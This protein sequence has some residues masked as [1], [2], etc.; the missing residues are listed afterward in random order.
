[1]QPPPPV[2]ETYVTPPN[3]LDR[4]AAFG[5]MATFAIVLAYEP[6]MWVDQHTFPL[7]GYVVYPVE[8]TV[9]KILFPEA[10]TPFRGNIGA[11]LIGMLY[12]AI[13]ALGVGVLGVILGVFGW[14]FRGATFLHH[15]FSVV[16]AFV[17]AMHRRIATLRNRA[18]R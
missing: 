7:L 10:M 17:R 11:L 3:E 16:A 15:C 6:M 2:Y 1:M 9:N 14:L 8:W 13:L 12:A 4:F 5:L 18:S